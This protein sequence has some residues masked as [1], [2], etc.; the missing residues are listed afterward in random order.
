MWRAGSPQ[1]AAQGEWGLLRGA[2]RTQTPLQGPVPA[3][4]SR[5]PPPFTR[6]FVNE[7]LLCAR[8]Q[9]WLVPEHKDLSLEGRVLTRPALVSCAEGDKGGDC[10]GE[11]FPEEGLELTPER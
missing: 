9:G 7:H 5:S 6:Q 10:P 2:R 4:R 1:E 3:L 8:Q 11:P